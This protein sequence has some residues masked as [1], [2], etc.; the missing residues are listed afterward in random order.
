[1]RADTDRLNALRAG[2]VGSVFKW[3]R[4]MLGRVQMRTAGEVGCPPAFRARGAFSITI[5]SWPKV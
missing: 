2:G 4:V 3:E 5:S 1:L